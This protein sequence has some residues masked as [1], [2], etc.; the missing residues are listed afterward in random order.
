VNWYDEK[1]DNRALARRGVPN[2]EMS[3]AVGPLRVLV[4]TV[5][6]GVQQAVNR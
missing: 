2:C 1:A 6:I 3:R 5:R 4:S